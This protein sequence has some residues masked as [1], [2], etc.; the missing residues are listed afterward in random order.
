MT[1]YKFPNNFLRGAATAANEYIPTCRVIEFMY[2]ICCASASTPPRINSIPQKRLDLLFTFMR[3]LHLISIIPCTF[4]GQNTSC[5]GGVFILPE[6]TAT[7][8]GAIQS[9]H[10]YRGNSLSIYG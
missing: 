1:T 10:H 2:P 3:S 5:A 8:P 6:W 9:R 7:H 4:L